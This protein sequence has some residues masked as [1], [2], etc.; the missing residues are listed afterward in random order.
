MNFKNVPKAEDLERLK[1]LNETGSTPQAPPDTRV[2]PAA[3]EIP[4]IPKEEPQAQETVPQEPA[5]DPIAEAGIEVK[6][7]PLCE[8]LES[9]LKDAEALKAVSSELVKKVKPLL[10]AV[11]SLERSSGDSKKLKLLE[12]KMAAIKT[13]T[14]GL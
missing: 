14:A 3:P 6:T 13:L 8:Q 7:L 5:V 12:D 11:A 2:M 10:K 4:V 1:E 9:V